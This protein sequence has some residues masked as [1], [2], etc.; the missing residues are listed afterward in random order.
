MGH[1]PYTKLSVQ[2]PALDLIG[3][4]DQLSINKP[5]TGPGDGTPSTAA[6]DPGTRSALQRAQWSASRGEMIHQSKSGNAAPRWKNKCKNNKPPLHCHAV[7]QTLITVLLGDTC[8]FH[9]SRALRL[10]LHC[11]H[12]LFVL[13]PLFLNK[14]I[15]IT[16]ANEKSILLAINRR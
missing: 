15:Y 11:H 9:G 6:W 3:L 1:G 14:F 5:I 2:I 12:S 10:N 16:A 13:T 7:F 4:V 8:H